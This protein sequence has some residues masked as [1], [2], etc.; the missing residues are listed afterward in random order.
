MAYS[1]PLSLLPLRGSAVIDSENVKEQSFIVA[2]VYSGGPQRESDGDEIIR[3][4]FVDGTAKHGEDYGTPGGATSGELKI[5]WGGANSAIFVPLIV[6]TLSERDETFFI[7]F[8]RIN[9]PGESQT[10]K[11]VITDRPLW[12]PAPL[13]LELEEPAPAWWPPGFPEFT[14][15]QEE[16]PGPEEEGTTNIAKEKRRIEDQSNAGNETTDISNITSGDIVSQNININGTVVEKFFFD[17]SSFATP[18]VDQLGG[19]KLP[20]LIR[21]LD[22]DDQ[23]TGGRGDDLIHGNGGDD[24]INGNQGDDLI[25]GGHGN[26]IAKGGKN[27]DTI[28]LGAGDDWANGNKGDDLI[29]G[30]IGNDSLT[31]GKGNDVLW[32]GEGADQFFMSRGSDVIKDFDFSQGDKVVISPET[33]VSLTGQDGTALLQ[34]KDGSFLFEGIN[35]ADFDLDNFVKSA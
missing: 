25:E 17:M 23:F 26:D 20:D 24:W 35:T 8:D 3:Y 2:G 30:G 16:S 10:A 12:E 6:D 33:T 5:K 32:G 28:K 15:T 34:T 14:D 4:T 7:R 9:K 13:P 21:L 27:M 31:G 11:I 29:N 1:D 18:V 22:G 19:S